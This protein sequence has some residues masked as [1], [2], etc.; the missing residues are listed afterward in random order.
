M[1]LLLRIPSLD[2]LVD[3]PV[4]PVDRDV[5]HTLVKILSRVLEDLRLDSAAAAA[6]V[7][8]AKE[9]EANLRTHQWRRASLTANGSSFFTRD[10]RPIPEV[11]RRVG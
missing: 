11:Y 1:P 6:V 7:V 4:D 2:L 9:A 8:E 5:I 10:P 3:L